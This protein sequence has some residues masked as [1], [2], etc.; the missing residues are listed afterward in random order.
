MRLEARVTVDAAAIHPSPCALEP[1]GGGG[2]SGL[3]R[4]GFEVALARWFGGGCEY[5]CIC[6]ANCWTS[7]IG[8]AVFVGPLARG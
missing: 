7:G 5:W 3:W 8:T 1:P 6:R 4:K 2:G